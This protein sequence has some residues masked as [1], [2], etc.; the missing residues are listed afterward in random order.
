MGAPCKDIKAYSPLHILISTDEAPMK[1]IE[2]LVRNG[3]PLNVQNDTGNT[4]LHLAVFWGH[5]DVVKLLVEEGAKMDLRN[6]KGRI[7]LDIAG[8][9][10]HRDIAEYIAQKS[11]KP[12]PKMKDRQRKTTAMNAPLEPPNPDRIDKK[13]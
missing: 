7:P 5:F 8:L 4:P 11:G 2:I 3:A 1:L 12:L 10:G 6:D 9:Y 13:N